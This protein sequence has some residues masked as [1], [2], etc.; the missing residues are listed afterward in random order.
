MR[1]KATRAL[2]EWAGAS[3]I[4][5]MTVRLVQANV[6]QDVVVLGVVLT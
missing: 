1:I 5:G 6:G 2:G 3:D 4:S